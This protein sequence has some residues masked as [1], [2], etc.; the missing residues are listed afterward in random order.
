VTEVQL[1]ERLVC[2]QEIGGSIPLVSTQHIPYLRVTSPNCCGEF[3]LEV[4]RPIEESWNSRLIL[5]VFRSRERL[6]ENQA[7][8]SS[9]KRHTPF[10]SHFDPGQFR[11]AGESGKCR[12]PQT[13][14]LSRKWRPGCSLDV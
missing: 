8:S 4:E 14:V 12:R 1:G 3:R 2:N 9:Q 5:R 7:L 11:G 6:G 13:A 10:M